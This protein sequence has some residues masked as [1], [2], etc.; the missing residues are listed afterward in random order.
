MVSRYMF[1]QRPIQLNEHIQWFARA[2]NDP[3]RTLLIFERDGQ[4]KGHVNF[5]H[6]PGAIAEWGFYIAPDSEKGTGTQLTKS[7]LKYAF[8]ELR[9]HKVSAQ[10]LAYNERSIRL[11]H[12]LHFQQEGILRSQHFDGNNYHNIHCFGL[13]ASEWQD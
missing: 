12:K 1:D 8:Q 6:K 11:H 4:P 10:V 9:L 5:T 3:N 2:S 13:L 7:A